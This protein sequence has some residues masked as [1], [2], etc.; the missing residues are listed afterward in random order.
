MRYTDPVTLLVE[1]NYGVKELSANSKE[2]L[3][4]Y[5]AELHYLVINGVNLKLNTMGVLLEFSKENQLKERVGFG[6]DWHIVRHLRLSSEL[7][8]NRPKSY[9]SAFELVTFIH[10][11]F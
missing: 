4:T 5:H 6:F 3:A 10:W 2:Q 7:R 1:L 8:F 9:A 11:Y